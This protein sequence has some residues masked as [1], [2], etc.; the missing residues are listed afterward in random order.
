M[1]TNNSNDWDKQLEKL[2]NKQGD[3]MSIFQV[4]KS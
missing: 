1:L 4:I 2:G 3:L